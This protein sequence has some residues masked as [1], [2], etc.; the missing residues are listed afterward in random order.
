MLH[1]P[2]QS[3]CPCAAELQL[4]GMASYMELLLAITIHVQAGF[5]LG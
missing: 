5:Q 1:N 3:I 4:A 2:P